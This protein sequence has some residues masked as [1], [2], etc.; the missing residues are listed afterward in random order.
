MNENA[1]QLIEKM[2]TIASELMRDYGHVDEDCLIWGDEYDDFGEM[3]FAVDKAIE[4]ITDGLHHDSI[5][6]TRT[7]SNTTIVL[8][9][10][11][12]AHYISYG[13]DIDWDDD[14][15]QIVIDNY[16]MLSPKSDEAEFIRHLAKNH[17]EKFDKI[18]GVSVCGNR[19]AQ[20]LDWFD[21]YGKITPSEAVQLFLDAWKRC[22]IGDMRGA[23]ENCQ[24]LQKCIR[25]M[26]EEE[27]EVFPVKI[28][29]YFE[30]QDTWMNIP[31]STE[32]RI[33]TYSCDNEMETPRVFYSESPND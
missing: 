25:K 21:S 10:G 16:F 19:I 18:I 11:N 5:E 15:P 3:L 6:I 22:K 27:R 9:Q 17:P 13:H 1:R 28:T 7:P 14:N 12:E 26:N 32:A 2:F 4:G 20:S 8:Y 33:R 24:A 29:W 23:W 31:L 30:A